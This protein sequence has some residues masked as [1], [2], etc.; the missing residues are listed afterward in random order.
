[1]PA[2][3]VLYLQWEAVLFY[4]TLR[5]VEKAPL[6]RFFDFLEQHPDLK[7]ETTEKDAIGRSVEV[8]FVNKFKIIYWVDPAVGEIKV[9]KL[10]RLEKK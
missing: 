1:M 7:G 4:R 9:L 3:F 2:S 5:H 8:K 10:E 6:A